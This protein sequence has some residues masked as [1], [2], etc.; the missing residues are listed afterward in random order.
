MCAGLP[1]PV[2][3]PIAI[4]HRREVGLAVLTYPVAAHSLFNMWVQE[5]QSK[6]DVELKDLLPGELVDS[7]FLPG[8]MSSH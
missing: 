5:A 1:C 6:S 8:T 7:H 4:C 3:K 2:S